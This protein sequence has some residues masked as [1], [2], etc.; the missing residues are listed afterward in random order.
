M[1]FA[2]MLTDERMARFYGHWSDLRANRALPARSDLD[3]ADIKQL[4]PH[5]VIKQVVGDRFLIRLMGTEVV[6]RTGENFTGRYLDEIGEPGA[7][8]DFVV[9]VYGTVR[10]GRKPVLSETDLSARAAAPKRIRRLSL[11]FAGG[12][13]AAVG[14]V[15]SMV[16]FSWPE[17]GAPSVITVD[18]AVP[19][20][21]RILR[22]DDAA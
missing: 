13:G 18:D 22:I 9:K 8:R 3:P 2:S 1:S 6:D 4:L 7:Y 10:D 16:L 17:P 15:V 20:Q 14:Y 19:K 12:D 11:P 21:H 5:I